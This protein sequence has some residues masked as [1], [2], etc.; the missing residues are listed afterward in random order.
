MITPT[1][2]YLRVHY[3]LRPAKQV[4]R[5]MLVDALH[6]LSLGGFQIRDYQYTGLGSIYFID[7]ILFHKLLGIDDMLSVEYSEKIA[8][9]VRFNRPFDCVRVEIASIGDVI[10]TLSRDKRHIIWMD[11][12]SVL[13][14]RH[15]DDLRLASSHLAPG[16][17]ILVTL[18][19]EPPGDSTDGPQDWREYLVG[20]AG[21][22]GTGANTCAL[23]MDQGDDN[24]SSVDNEVHR[25]FVNVACN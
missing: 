18:D 21:D 12:D 24:G 16:S 20:Q 25:V 22:Y 3:E 9:R 10:P 19:V 4:E 13:L 11:Y 7:F 2:S 8:R 15:L 5:R 17:I 1:E 23:G 6:L 14:S